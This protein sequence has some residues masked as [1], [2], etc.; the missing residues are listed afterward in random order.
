MALIR[1]W[2]YQMQLPTITAI[3]AMTAPILLRIEMRERRFIDCPRF[4]VF[5]G[6][7]ERG[8]G[9]RGRAGERAVAE[10]RRVDGPARPT[11]GSAANVMGDEPVFRIAAAFPAATPG[12]YL[13]SRLK[14]R[15][16][17]R[18]CAGMNGIGLSY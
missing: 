3:R 5:Q 12:Q 10:T 14:G 11:F 8:S 17:Q 18:S 13:A 6:G 2:A 16:I 9:G 4:R 1:I 7:I 15:Y